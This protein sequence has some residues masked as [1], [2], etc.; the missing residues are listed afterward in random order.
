M[1]SFFQNL[2]LAGSASYFYY[3]YRKRRES[4]VLVVISFL[5]IALRAITF[6]INNYSDTWIIGTY[7]NYLL[8]IPVFVQPVLI[9]LFVRSFIPGRL[10]KG[11]IDLLHFIP[12]VFF[13]VV[14]QLWFQFGISGPD[15]FG[16][17]FNQ[18]ARGYVEVA[19]IFGYSIASGFLIVRHKDQLPQYPWLMG[20]VVISILI[21]SVLLYGTEYFRWIE[22]P[23][24][25]PYIFAHLMQAVMVFLL[26]FAVLSGLLHWEDVFTQNRAY[27]H[28][29]LDDWKS[30]EI[31]MEILNL[32]ENKQCFLDPGLKL[33]DLSRELGCTRFQVSQVL[34]ERF[35]KNFYELVNG[36]RVKEAQCKLRSR[37]YMDHNISQIAYE[38]GFNSIATFNRSFK[39]ICGITPSE[40][41]SYHQSKEATDIDKD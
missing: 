35:G 30:E 6:Y 34:S 29:G 19:L 28:S 26:S 10:Q 18:T 36:Y 7:E 31:R 20:I 23:S 32:M 12:A 4:I 27:S 37:K 9:F 21:G 25:N 5:L 41:R 39:S 38:S 1:F 14:I 40:Y 24:F 15:F 3:I 22:H 13:F 8:R 2:V 33:D 11:L 16:Y 17:V